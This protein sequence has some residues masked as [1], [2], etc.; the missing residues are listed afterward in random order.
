M[1]QLI[2]KRRIKIGILFNFSPK[3]MGGVV[4]VI[5]LIKTLNFLDDVEKPEIILFYRSDLKNFA[6][7]IYYPY[8]KTVEWQFPSVYQGYLKS[9]IF[10]RNVFVDDILKQFD[11]DGLYPFND[12]PV[13]VKTKTKIVSWYADLQHN[14]YPEFFTRRK[15]IERNA[16]IRLMLMNSQNII[17]SSKAVEHDFQKFYPQSKR[18]KTNIFHFVSVIDDFGE[19]NFSSLQEKYRLPEKYFMISNQ[20]HRHKNHKVLLTALVRLKK[21]GVGIH[22]AMTGRFPDASLSP[23]MQELHQIIDEHNLNSQISFL[24]VIPRNEQLFLMKHSQAV[25]QPS[26]FEGWSTVIEDAKSLQVPVIASEIPVNIEQLGSDGNF[27]EP[28]DDKK[29]SEI[30]CNFPLRNLNDVFYGEYRTRLKDA[31]QVF[32][33]VFQS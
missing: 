18:I 33:N 23:Y 27:F 28:D 29:L 8:F 26:L 5:N 9:F 2:N 16:R 4:Y 30:L 31:A 6:D 21:R 11:L 1:V 19:L 10:R 22:L 13:K 14:Y 3:W 15:I 17:V 12:F 32:L 7:E 20:F 25:L 24:G